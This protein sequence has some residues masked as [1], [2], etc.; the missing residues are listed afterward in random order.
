MVDKRLVDNKVAQK[1]VVDKRMV[2]NKVAVK[3]VVD[4]E[5]WI[6]QVGIMFTYLHRS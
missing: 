1:K 6:Q 3:K 2:D 5:L 4:D